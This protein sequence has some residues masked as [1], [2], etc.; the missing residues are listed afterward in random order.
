MSAPPPSAHQPYNIN[1][2]KDFKRG[3][4]HDIG[5]FSSL[6]DDSA[7]DNW[8]CSTVAQ[9]RAQDIIEVLDP[10]YNPK[11][12]EDM[13][14]FLEKQKFMYAIFEKTILTDKGK[15]LVHQNQQFF[16]AALCFFLCSRNSA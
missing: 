13:H 3:I 2:V 16:D 5:Q 15:A 12:V 8:K 14:L 6:K 9:A 10:N 7:W 1:L 4:K 11:M